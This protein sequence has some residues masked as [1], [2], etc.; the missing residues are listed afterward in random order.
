MNLE[1][2]EGRLKKAVT[3]LK[4]IVSLG[5][6]TEKPGFLRVYYQVVAKGKT[7]SYIFIDIPIEEAEKAIKQEIPYA[8]REANL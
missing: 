4:P 6:T 1:K 8:E 7:I 3:S 5:I 2:L